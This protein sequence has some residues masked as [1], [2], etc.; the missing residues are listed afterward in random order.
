MVQDSHRTEADDE[1]DA[2][3]D[4]AD[5]AQRQ[6]IAER[7]APVVAGMTETYPWLGTP[8]EQSLHGAAAT[9]AVVGEAIAGL[10]N[11]AQLDVLGRMYA[12]L[13]RHPTA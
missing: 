1:F 13:Q 7:L 8:G 11:P 5:D 3:T 9:G 2:L 6:S 12:L 10:Y 4:D